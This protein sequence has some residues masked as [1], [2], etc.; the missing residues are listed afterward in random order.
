MD[1]VRVTI[2]T[3]ESITSSSSIYHDLQL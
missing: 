3:M 2:S 1:I